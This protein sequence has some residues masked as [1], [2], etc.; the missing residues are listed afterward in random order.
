MKFGK[1]RSNSRFKRNNRIL[2]N[3]ICFSFYVFRN[4]IW[5]QTMSPNVHKLKGNQ[6]RQNIYVILKTGRNLRIGE[7]FDAQ[8]CSLVGER[9]YH[10]LLFY[11]K[12]ERVQILWNRIK[13]LLFRFFNQV[14]VIKIRLHV[15]S[16][17]YTKFNLPR[18]SLWLENWRQECKPFLYAAL[19]MHITVRIKNLQT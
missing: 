13:I 5:L 8:L 19:E 2:S 1:M 12:I 7:K 6:F 11:V 14:V 9:Y 10:T 15:I 3:I 16:H 4:E 17:K 18:G